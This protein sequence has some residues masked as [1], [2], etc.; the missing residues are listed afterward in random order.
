MGCEVKGSEAPR[1]G[2]VGVKGLVDRAARVGC[3]CWMESSPWWRRE[4]GCGEL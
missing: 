4:M 2:K 1:R 3:R